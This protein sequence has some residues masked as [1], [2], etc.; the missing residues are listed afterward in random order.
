MLSL[1]PKNKIMTKYYV[2][3]AIAILISSCSS[4]VY[5]P[6]LNL[7]TKTLKEKEIDLHGGMEMLPETIPEEIGSKAT[8]GLNGQVTYGFSDRFNLTSKGWVSFKEITE[9]LR[10][11][12][13][14]S[15][16]V[17]KKKSEHSSIIILPKLGI[18][19]NGPIVTG[20]GIETALV[21]QN[22]ITNNLS[23]HGGSG[24]LWGFQG[25][26]KDYNSIEQLRS[27]MA[28]GIMGYTGLGWQLSDKFRLNAE[29]NPI[30][31]INTFE[32]STHFIIS[33]TV[34]LGYTIKTK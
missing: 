1:T 16:Q 8:L 9:N 23:W 22:K 21:Y 3:L 15:A 27:P 33:P 11:G 18:T 26:G 7:T 17:I 28:F 29:V 4:Q 19:F 30:Y 14:L 2:Y 6:S 20:Y 10:G 24:V 34:G 5:S 31:Q 13:S 32:Q 12:Y 25:L